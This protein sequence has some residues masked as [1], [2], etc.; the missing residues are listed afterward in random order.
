M[1]GIRDIAKAAG[2]KPEDV[3]DVFE[4][5]FKLVKAGELVRVQGFGS[6]EKKKFPGR[7]LTSPVINDGEPTTFGPSYR[8]AFKQSDQCK[9][10]MNRTLL[11]K[12]TTTK[13]K[14]KKGKRK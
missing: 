13:K 6:F 3:S 1:A 7:T 4:A 2:L 12:K 8:V 9:R 14:G 11:K 10:R 5:V